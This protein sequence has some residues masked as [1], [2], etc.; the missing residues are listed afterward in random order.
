MPGSSYYACCVF[1][2]KYGTLPFTYS[3]FI[4][5]VLPFFANALLE[6]SLPCET[7]RPASPSAGILRA[8]HEQRL[9]ILL[10]YMQL[11]WQLVCFFN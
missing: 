6:K 4:L 9:H 8:C 10:I 1:F 7:L 3:G 5:H 2:L 11:E